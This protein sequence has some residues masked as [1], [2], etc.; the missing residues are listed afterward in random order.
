MRGCEG[1][2]VFVAQRDSIGFEIVV[3]CHFSTVATRVSSFSRPQ[4]GCY[5][6]RQLPLSGRRVNDRTYL[7]N[8]D[9]SKSIALQ[10]NSSIDR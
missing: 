2:P 10:G 1:S 3:R 7:F 9:H 6:S 8:E 5:V 4:H